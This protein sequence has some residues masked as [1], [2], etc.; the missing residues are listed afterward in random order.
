MEDPRSLVLE[1]LQA[2][3]DYEQ[4]AALYARVGKNR[5]ITD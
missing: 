3:A 2:G 1:W 4:G 5:N